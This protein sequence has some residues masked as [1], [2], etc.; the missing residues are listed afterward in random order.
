MYMTHLLKPPSAKLLSMGWGFLFLNI[1]PCSFHFSTV[2]MYIYYALFIDIAQGLYHSFSS[3]VQRNMSIV[4][5]LCIYICYTARSAYSVWQFVVK[6]FHCLLCS[7]LMQVLY[8]GIKHCYSKP[9]LQNCWTDVL[10]LLYRAL[11]HGSTALLNT[12]SV[13]VK[14]GLL[15]L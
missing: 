13:K 15:S 9:V 2:S 7:S 12:R 6:W 14:L 8:T 11:T 1:L 10:H 3:F 4:I 5:A